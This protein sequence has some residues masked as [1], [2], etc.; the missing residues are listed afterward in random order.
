MSEGLG[1][2]RKFEAEVTH[3]PISVELESFG[4]CLFQED[5]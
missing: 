4:D 5:L 2:G 3:G 1:Q